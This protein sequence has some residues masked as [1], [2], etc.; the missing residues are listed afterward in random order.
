M[1]AGLADSLPEPCDN[2][3]KKRAHIDVSMGPGVD[4]RAADS[5]A[6]LTAARA[7]V[8]GQVEVGNFI[9]K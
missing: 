1:S 3:G 5:I 7:L 8:D 6:I 2:S 9:I 4:G